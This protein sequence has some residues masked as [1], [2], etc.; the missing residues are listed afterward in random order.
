[1]KKAII[2]LLAG[3]LAVSLVSGCGS[4]K[5]KNGDSETVKLNWVVFNMRGDREIY[6]ESLNRVM[7][8]KGLPYE[9]TFNSIEPEFHGDY[10]AYVE[11][12][13]KQVKEGNYDL[14]SCPGLQNCYDTYQMAVDAELLEPM[15]EFLKKT[16]SGTALKGAYPSVVW[17]SLERDGEIYGVLTPNM[18]LDY[19]AVFQQEYAKKYG[20]DAS[21]VTLLNLEDI[22]TKV[23]EGEKE[24]GNGD[25]V[26][27][28]GWQYLPWGAFEL[29][30]CELI[31]LSKKD[32]S[33]TA[34]SALENETTLE[35]FRRIN[36][37][38][39]QWLIGSELDQNYLEKGE[40]LVS[41]CYS[42]SEAA[43]ENQVR[44][45]YRIPEEI[46]LEAVKLPEFTQS[47]SG[48]G[49]KTGVGRNSTHKKAA[50]EVLAAI[51]TNQE[52]SDALVYGE[53]N[54]SYEQ[55]NGYAEST[56]DYGMT[57][58][59][60]QITFGNSLLT[61]PSVRESKE[62]NREMSARLENGKTSELMG[63]S[64]DLESIGPQ[65]SEIN[66]LVLEQY[67]DLLNGK[68]TN[69]E[70]DLEKL[71]RDADELGMQE[72]LKELNRQLKER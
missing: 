64:F 43:A 21:E 23:K 3:L 54:V 7:K 22:M 26:V 8:K 50:M 45:N 40:F 48:N 49:Y 35:H 56:E 25:F 2:K 63:F 44:S 1:M 37:W 53:E 47:F 29:S 69:P 61:T 30:P 58:F 10:R 15:G 24:S 19:Y 36:S 28:T 16:D 12:Y 65:I 20:I 62:K 70:G 41:G 33:W 72:V 59:L 11:E 39:K 67:Q 32:G 34:E 55:K 66:V 13:L 38:G 57:G 42:Y 14:V 9:I 52:L 71:R 18:N 17:E 68:S 31:I 6:Y 5:G 27:S 4:K 60:Q 51:Y 46:P